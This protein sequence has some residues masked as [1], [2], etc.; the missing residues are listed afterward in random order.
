MKDSAHR[1]ATGTTAKP[2]G[3]D[4]TASLS[5]DAQHRVSL[6]LR[7]V[8]HSAR[9]V[10]ITFPNARTHDFVVL[11]S[12]GR[13]VWRWSAGR[14]FTQAL[15]NRMLGVRDTLS[16]QEKWTP[17]AAGGTFTAVAFLASSN[18]PFEERTQ[19]TVLPATISTAAR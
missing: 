3:P 16:F 15:Q 7:V 5:V 11:D 1:S 10:E 9:R 12:V 4:L 17:P 6:A 2:A 8:N 18:H 19:F 14:M 13:E